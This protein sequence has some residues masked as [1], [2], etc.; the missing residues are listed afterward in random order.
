M[1]K[2][3]IIVFYSLYLFILL[4]FILHTSNDPQ[5][6]GK[7]TIKYFEIL[8]V[9]ILLFP[10]SIWL[11]N[12][13]FKISNFKYKKKKYQVKPIHKAIIFIIFCLFLFFISETF[14]RNK[15]KDKDPLNYLYSIN[16]YHPFLQF[17]LTRE[18]IL[19]INS[20]NFRAEEISKKKDEN[21]FRIFI[22][23][24]STVLN[25]GISYDNLFSKILQDKLSNEYPDKKIE[26]INAGND[27]YTS[28]HSLIQYLF[29]IKDYDPDLIIM[30]QGVNDWYYSCNS[31]ISYGE[32]KNDYSNFYS[33]TAKMVFNRFLE[34]PLISFNF[35]TFALAKD[36]FEKNSYS[37]LLNFVKSKNKYTGVYAN[38]DKYEFYDLTNLPSLNAYQRNIQEF[39]QITKNDNVPLILANQATLYK[40]NM[41]RDERNVL[42]FG[43]FHCMKDGKYPTIKSTSEG[44]GKFNEI[45]RK[46]AI[47]NELNFIDLDSQIPK[48]LNYFT[49]DAH[50]TVLANKLISEILFQKI[51]S[52][53]LIS[54]K[55]D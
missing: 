43:S 20:D 37:D 11:I 5:I 13:M 53:N 18:N 17:Q 38:P 2:I 24:G 22:L 28:E 50:Y 16:N 34:K 26:V 10:V 14:L 47:E 6:F 55:H 19:H 36:I 31:P 51:V 32:Y 30:W 40:E 4:G 52:E 39:A 42:F 27:G 3:I 12:Y 35:M 54:Q 21:S 44:L 25:S 45:T 23:G 9:L 15:Y 29:K 48:N 33:A 1:K 8:L 41:S 46:T 7:Y 49:D